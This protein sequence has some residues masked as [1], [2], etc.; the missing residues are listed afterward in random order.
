MIKK[1]QKKINY[2]KFFLNL[3]MIE[4]IIM[5]YY[6]LKQIIIMKIMKKLKNQ[7]HKD[8]QLILKELV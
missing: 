2:K 4:I 8:K 5:K 3:P 7:I 6:Q 1:T